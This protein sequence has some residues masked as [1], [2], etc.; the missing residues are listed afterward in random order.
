MGHELC[1]SLRIPTRRSLRP[2]GAGG[3]HHHVRIR[4][5]R[6]ERPGEHRAPGWRRGWGCG[7][8]ALGLVWPGEPGARRRIGTSDE[9]RL[10][11]AAVDVC[12][13]DRP[14]GIGPVDE[15][16]ADRQPTAADETKNNSTR[17][18]QTGDESLVDAAAVEV[19]PPDR[20]GIHVIPVD[21]L[22]VHCDPR[23]RL[24]PRDEVIV[25]VAAV[26]VRPPDR[27]IFRIRPIDIATIRIYCQASRRTHPRP[28][29]RDEVRVDV[30]AVDVRASNTPSS[31][32]GPVDV[33]VVNRHAEGIV[34]TRERD[35]APVDV[36]AIDVRPR[37]RPDDIAPIDVLH[38]GGDGFRTWTSP[39]RP[40][41]YEVLVGAA[42]VE[43]RPPDRELI[44]PVDRSRSAGSR[45]ITGLHAGRGRDRDRRERRHRGHHARQ[46]SH[47][48]SEKP[49][50]GV[51]HGPERAAA[52]VRLCGLGLGLGLGFGLRF[53]GGLRVMSS[54]G[55][56]RLSDGSATPSAGSICGL[57]VAMSI[58]GS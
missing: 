21:V 31:C 11:V 57:L 34:T 26:E 36:A 32:V 45:H 38:I 13:T 44:G 47:D 56:K 54:S 58:S 22:R 4:A 5:A 48:D 8:H 16:P 42:A 23:R 6:I 19:R 20:P 1:R 3:N 9:P 12:P 24:C 41:R 46:R 43:V 39:A 53:F 17:Q 18:M 28:T 37:D 2:R 52:H 30:T 35:K 49:S 50:A 55:S 10:D 25:G 14:G 51:G 7:P 40:L 27:P 33:S 15:L 29:E